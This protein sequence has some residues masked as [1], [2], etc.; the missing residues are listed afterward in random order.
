[1]K[2]VTLKIDCG[3]VDAEHLFETD[4]SADQWNNLT[5]E[6]RNELRQEA[7]VNYIDVYAVICIDD[8]DITEDNSV[9]L[10]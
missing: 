10:K 7:I 4:L 2:T 1:M 5:E 9:E 3:Y 6:E 8:D